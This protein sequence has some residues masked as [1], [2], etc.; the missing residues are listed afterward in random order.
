MDPGLSLLSLEYGQWRA[1]SES[2]YMP[3]VTR[4]LVVYVT[5]QA[6][7]CLQAFRHDKF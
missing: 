2:W 5:R 6:N 4:G 7:L 3:A 1:G